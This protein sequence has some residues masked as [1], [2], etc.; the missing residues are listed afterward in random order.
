M[1]ST[2]EYSLWQR[3]WIKDGMLPE[4]CMRIFYPQNSH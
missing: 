2:I 4:S 3:K 1:P